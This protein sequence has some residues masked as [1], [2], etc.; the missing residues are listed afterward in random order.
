VTP[1]RPHLLVLILL[2]AVLLFAYA[3][4]GV[5][6]GLQAYISLILFA[7][8]L[9]L[10]SLYHLILWLVIRKRTVNNLFRIPLYL[11][12]VAVVLLLGVLSPREP[13]L[14]NQTSP[15]PSPSKRF[16]MK[17]AMEDDQ[18]IISIDGKAGQPRYEDTESDFRGQFNVYWI[19]DA[20]DRLWLYNSDD[21]RVYYWAETPSGWQRSEWEVK[22]AVGF[23]PPESLFPDYAK[24]KHTGE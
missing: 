13:Q 10:S 6:N 21:G 4:H 9:G 12:P 11:A 20:A 16:T 3:M 1:Q 24:G 15:L 18:W 5:Q 23:A 14:P 7:W 8:L 22:Q 2:H 19:W 17:M